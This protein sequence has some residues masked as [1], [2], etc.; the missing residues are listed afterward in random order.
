MSK[1]TEWEKEYYEKEGKY[2]P[3]DPNIFYDDVYIDLEN[4]VENVQ[5]KD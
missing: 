4:N 3:M 2:H 5:K 1:F